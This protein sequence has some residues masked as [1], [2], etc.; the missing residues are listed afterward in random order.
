MLPACGNSVFGFIKVLHLVNMFRG[1]PCGDTAALLETPA[2]QR[3]VLDKFQMCIYE[4]AE[5]NVSKVQP[6]IEVAEGSCED[7]CQ[8]AKSSEAWE[9]KF[10]SA[11]S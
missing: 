4:E 7:L 9:A 10:V 8:R 11:S 6:N 3:E 2:W 1:M 5:Q